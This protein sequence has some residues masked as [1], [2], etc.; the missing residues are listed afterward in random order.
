MVFK[1]YY[2]LLGLETPRVSIDEI[3]SAYRIAA[4]KYHPDLNVGDSL[5]EENIIRKYISEEGKSA[6]FQYIEN[7]KENMIEPGTH[8]ICV[9]DKRI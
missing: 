9:K 7:Q 8:T 3:K 1:D 6:C 2:K 5:A 4:K